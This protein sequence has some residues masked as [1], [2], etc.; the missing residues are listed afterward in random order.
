MLR[1]H[2]K[3]SCQR[4][5]P[6]WLLNTQTRCWYIYNVEIRINVIIRKERRNLKSKH[7]LDMNFKVEPGDL[8][9]TRSC[10]TC[11]PCP[12]KMEWYGIRWTRWNERICVIVLSVVDCL[13]KFVNFYQEQSISDQYLTRS[14]LIDLLIIKN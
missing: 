10:S 9:E 4:H 1:K 7:V 12:I 5:R 2:I 3:Y 6:S 14:N 13:H 8:D 11:F